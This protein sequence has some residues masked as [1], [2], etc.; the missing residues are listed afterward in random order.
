[1]K[2]QLKANKKVKLL[3]KEIYNKELLEIEK[4]ENNNVRFRTSVSCLKCSTFLELLG[5][6]PTAYND[7]MVTGQINLIKPDMICYINNKRICHIK[8]LAYK[9]GMLEEKENIDI[10]KVLGIKE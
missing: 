10:N 4:T 6:F 8:Y 7:K 2:I 3:A 5:E 1:M 9:L